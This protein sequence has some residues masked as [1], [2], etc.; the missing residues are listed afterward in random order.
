M[1][2]YLDYA[3]STPMLPSVIEAM[4]ACMLESYGNPSSVHHHGRIARHHIESARKQIAELLDCSPAEIIF[5]SG[6]TEADNMAIRSAIEGLGVQH[7]ITSH[8]EHHAVLHC[9]SALQA[10]KG[11]QIH[12]LQPDE[13]GHLSLSE[14]DELLGQ[15][16]GPVLVSLMHG[17]NEIGTL[18]PITDFAH[19]AQSHRA[20]FMSDTVQTVGHF[21]IHLK[22]TP[23][24]FFTG[25]AHKFYGPKGVGFLYA[26]PEIKVSSLICGGGQER[27]QR[28]GTENLAAIV[29]MAQAL[30][31][32]YDNH[33]AIESHLCHLK[34]YFI[35]RLRESIPGVTFNGEIE[36]GRS[37]NTVIN[38]AFPG[39]DAESL[40]LFN[41]DIHQI[42]ASGG[43]ACS[44]GSV[45]PSHVLHAIGCDAARMANSVRFSIGWQTTQAEIDYVLSKLP[46]MVLA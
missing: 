41:L 4:T 29:G 13:K 16:P 25:A 32:V 38:V 3:A 9:L 46:T 18:L 30:Q 45:H 36:T 22:N 20:I 6:G 17:N 39:Q 1:R 11:I 19:C 40:I 10:S 43:S 35:D 42:S 14:L 44:S 23:V 26:N 28:A 27:N 37:L 15:L 12:Y 33:D 7:V 5:T 24:H 31:T 34:Q 21:P 8:L 2:V